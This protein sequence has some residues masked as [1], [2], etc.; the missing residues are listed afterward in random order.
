MFHEIYPHILNNR[1]KKRKPQLNDYLLIYNDNKVLVF[2]RDNNIF[3]TVAEAKNLYNI[4]IESLVYLLDIDITG[5]YFLPCNL[6]EKEGLTY[7]TVQLLRTKQ[8]SWLCFAAATAIHIAAWYENNRFCGKCAQRMKSSNT[9]RA[10]QC[11]HCG[12]TV[13]PRINPVV[14]V[15]VLSNDKLLLTKY[16][17]SQYKNYALIAGFMEIGETFEET[18]K[19]EVMEEVGLMVKNIRY[20]KSQPW[21]FSES[22]LTGFFADVDGNAEPVVD[23][24]ELSE[25]VWFLRDELPPDYSTFSLT[26][27]MIEHFH[28]NRP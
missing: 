2:D 12:Q 19:R 25:A 16:R 5:F 6:P 24:V 18:V 4:N 3:L 17:A 7:Q 9:E 15:A 22:I 23:G 27:E 11:P 8:P 1:Y 28:A 10:L 26:G 14:M 13:Y 21:A 20:F